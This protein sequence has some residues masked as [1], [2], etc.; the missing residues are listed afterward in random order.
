M[1]LGIVGAMPEEMEKVLL[2]I[3]NKTISE[4]GNRVYYEGEIAGMSVVGVFSRWGKVAAATTITNLILEYNV[5]QIL[6]TGIAGGLS[7]DLNIGDIIVAQ[8]LFQHDMDARPLIHRFEIPLTGKT[9]FEIADLQVEMGCNAVHNM[10]KNNKDF[11]NILT[12]NGIDSPKFYPGDIASGDLFIGTQAMRQ[13]LN[14]NLP[15][16]LCVDM[17]SA[18][19]A[20]VCDDYQIPLCVIRVISD[21]ADEKAHISASNFVTEHGGDY[22]LAIITEYIKLLRS[23]E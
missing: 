11:R 17:E 6:F 16:V 19:A 1:K 23:K 2:S 13:A 3:T 20:Q 5:D 18:A 14:R 22:S 7:D 4:R 15:S 10:L 9:S 21:A 12:E 8:R